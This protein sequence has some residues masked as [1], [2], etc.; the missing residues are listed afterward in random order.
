LREDGREEEEEEEEMEE[1]DVGWLP[2]VVW[3]VCVNLF[4]AFVSRLTG[5]GGGII[6][7]IRCE[8]RRG[9]STMQSVN[10]FVEL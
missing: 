8:G 2:G 6:D 7:H 3:C 5:F 1:M 10:V 9:Q 4:G